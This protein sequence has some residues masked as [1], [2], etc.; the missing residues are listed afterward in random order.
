MA[1]YTATLDGGE[2]GETQIE[3]SRFS[4]AWKR[5]VEWAR[6][7]DWSDA[8]EGTDVR[9]TLRVSSARQT[10]SEEIVVRFAEE[11][12]PECGDGGEHDWHQ[13]HS[14]VGG[15]KENPGYWTNGGMRHTSVENCLRCGMLRK[16]VEDEQPGQERRSVT[17][18]W[19]AKQEAK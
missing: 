18:E 8:D 15:I 16:T 5:A 9:A 6:E 14:A 1:T 13:D 4:T 10:R 19:P 2:G 7:G 12:E 17:Y 3:A 11:E